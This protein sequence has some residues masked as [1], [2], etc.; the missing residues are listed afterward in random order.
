[1]PSAGISLSCLCPVTPNKTRRKKSDNKRA[2]N[3]GAIVST[4]WRILP[5]ATKREAI[6]NEMKTKTHL[7]EDSPSILDFKSTAKETKNTMRNAA[8]GAK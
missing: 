7:F 3:Q 4:Y 6:H 1:M 2:A 5:T 8:T